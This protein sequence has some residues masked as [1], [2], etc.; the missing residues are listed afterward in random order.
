V[1]GLDRP[2]WLNHAAWIAAQPALPAASMLS[3]LARLTALHSRR[4]EGAVDS[5]RCQRVSL[6]DRA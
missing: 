2:A 4:S 3:H 6:P 1:V 5:G